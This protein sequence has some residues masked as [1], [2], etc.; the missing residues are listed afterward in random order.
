VFFS[1]AAMA[2]KF[3]VL[4]SNTLKYPPGFMLTEKHKVRLGAGEHF[5]LKAQNR[6]KKIYI[7]GPYV[8]GP[9]AVTSKGGKKC[10]KDSL[11]GVLTCLF[12][13]GEGCDCDPNDFTCTMICQNRILPHEESE[14]SLDSIMTELW[15]IIKPR[16][17][18]EILPPGSEKPSKT[19]KITVPNDPWLLVAPSD[20]DFCYRPD[21][22]LTIWRPELLTGQLILLTEPSDDQASS[23]AATGLDDLLVITLHAM[24]DEKTLP[25]NTYKAVWMAGKG[26]YRQAALL[27]SLH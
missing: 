18:N 3:E 23:K 6:A 19:D 12:I 24:P 11:I 14:P 5:V 21:K 10:K 25:S 16:L 1:Q 22:P 20:Q 13:K 26:C 17:F 4:S 15:N 27:L 7:D 9:Y 2:Q 8:E